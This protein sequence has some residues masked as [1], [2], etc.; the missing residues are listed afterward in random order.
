[1]KTVLFDLDGTLL[2]M[3]Q[4]EFL[5]AYFGGLAAHLAPHGFEPDKLV[6]SIWAGTAAMVNNDGSL[7]NEGAFWKCFEEIFGPDARKSESVLDEYYRTDFQ[8]VQQV[9][10]YAP[11]AKALVD[12]L[13]SAGVRVILATNP[14]F[15]A[16]A[17]HS[18]IRWAGLQ[19]EDFELVTTYENA[20]HCKP[21]PEYYRDI[22]TQLDLNAADCIMVGNDVGEDMIAQQLGMQV[23][24]LTPCLINKNNE[25]ISTWPH[26]DFAELRA[27]LRS[28]AF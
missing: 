10:G 7:T 2:P 1:M 24:L 13:K 11:Q 18:R 6:R 28:N 25:D 3:D 8:K 22:L 26:G 16:I 9:C 12:E 19:P 14:L 21:N 15:P 5:K 23:F 4:D 20:C 27:F 17:T